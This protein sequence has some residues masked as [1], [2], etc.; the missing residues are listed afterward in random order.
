MPAIDRGNRQ[1]GFTYIELVMVIVLL[2]IIAAAGAQMMG[3]GFQVYITGRNV[4]ESDWQ[5]RV[6]L[7]RMT[8]EIRSI[9]AP[10]D[11]VTMAAADLKFTDV[12]GNSIEY[13]LSS[14][15]LMRNT[16]SL[17]TGISGLS[18]TYLD[19]NGA[20]TATAAQ[21]YYIVVGFTATQGTLSKSFQTTVSP[22]NFP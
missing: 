1:A 11:I 3:R 20:V 17:A 8:R 10:A 22:R 6:A 2:A 16:Q 13:V 5:G 7:E 9:R 15:D 21:V 19:K 14:S 18:F 4:A 12:D